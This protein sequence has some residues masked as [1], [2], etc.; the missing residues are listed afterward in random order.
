MTISI[1]TKQWGNSMGI[2]IPK[3][4]V[5]ELKLKTG[6]EVLV[7]IELKDNPLKELFGFDKSKKISRKSV[8]GIR[9]E[10]ESRY[11]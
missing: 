8:I 4:K 10:L 9:K 7:T 5:D 3:E 2:I 6:Q 11:L 1:Q